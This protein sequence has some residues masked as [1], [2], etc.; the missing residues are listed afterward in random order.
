M[1]QAAVGLTSG[2]SRPVVLIT[3]AAGNLGRTLAGAL[4][5]NYRIVGLDRSTADA[6]YPIFAADFANPAAVELALIRVREQVGAR[7][8]SVVHLV[9]YFDQT[10][11]DNPLYQ[12]VNVDGTRNLLRALQA[13]EVEQFVY[14]S[15]MLVHAPNRPGEHMDEDQPFD[16]AYIYPKSKLAAE[17][18]IKADH[19]HIPYV[20][21]RLA[22]V[23]DEKSVIP[24]SH[25]RWRA[26]TAANFRATFTRARRSPVSR[27]CTRKT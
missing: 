8:A 15:T 10:G 3:G 4:A 24:R 5:T 7:I 12:S 9:A 26:S 11:E 17:E 27:C 14:A 20:I 19:G 23:Y 6:D 1:T 16:P 25:N 2:E 18:A 13:F 22:G 21:L